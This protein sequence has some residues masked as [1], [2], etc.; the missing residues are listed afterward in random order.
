M[1]IPEAVTQVGETNETP[2]EKHKRIK[3]E[4]EEN[5]EKLVSTYT[6]EELKRHLE[7]LRIQMKWPGLKQE[8][9]LRQRIEKRITFIENLQEVEIGQP[10]TQTT[11]R[12]SC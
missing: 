6:P 3:E 9:E 7:W 11:Q 8:E 5:I 2:K 4:I 12:H 10:A 1:P